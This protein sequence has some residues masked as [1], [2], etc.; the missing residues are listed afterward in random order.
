MR[1][2]SSTQ[3]SSGQINL[4]IRTSKTCFIACSQIPFLKDLLT[5]N[6]RE[7]MPIPRSSSRWR[8]LRDK[9]ITPPLLRRSRFKTNLSSSSVYTT[10]WQS[11]TELL[12]LPLSRTLEMISLLDTGRLMTQP[13]LKR[14]TSMS[15]KSWLWARNRPS[16]RYRSQL[17][18]MKSGTQILTSLS[19][20]M[21]LILKKGFPEM[22]QNAKLP[23][24]MR[25]SQVPSDFKK[26][27]LQFKEEL[28][29]LI[30]PLLDKMV[31]MEL[32][33]AC[34]QLNSFRKLKHLNLLRNS[35]TT[36]PASKKC[37]SPIKLMR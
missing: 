4:P 12:I 1:L 28:K 27:R 30:L 37:N 11:L 35:R 34:F 21:M 31:L 26:L 16:T 32:S 36:F 17:M 5:E 9:L 24:L 7:F 33:T 25:T 10:L 14:T 23:S 3:K 18:M 8:E 13:Q 15:T 22:I 19:S 20:S 6:R 2:G 29:M